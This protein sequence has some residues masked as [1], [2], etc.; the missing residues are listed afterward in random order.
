MISIPIGCSHSRWR[1][2]F[3]IVGEAAGRVS[4]PTREA[5]ADIPWG[6]IVSMRNR[7]L[8]AYF[9][10]DREVVW[11][12]M[13]EELPRLLPRLRALV[14]KRRTGHDQA[15]LTRRTWPYL[16]QASIYMSLTVKLRLGWGASS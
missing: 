10:I 5:V 15:S 11:K 16:Y 3:E 6:L 7:L 2:R 13:T 14:E 9:D 12:T 8:H 1:E 4:A